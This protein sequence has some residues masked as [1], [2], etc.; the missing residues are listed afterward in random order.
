MF[1]QKLSKLT[2]NK[3]LVKRHVEACFF[4]TKLKRCAYIKSIRRKIMR[5][6]FSL[7]DNQSR[8]NKFLTVQ[9]AREDII[10]ELDAIIQYENHLEQTTDV[11]AQQT[12]RDIVLEEKL[13][14]GQ[15]FGLLFSLDPESKTQF[16]KGLEEFN[17]RNR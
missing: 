5:R 17:S 6:F 11:A 2:T 15:L 8:P 3:R 7:V 16:E 10:G 14:V 4:L 13:H 9:N 12:I 1:N